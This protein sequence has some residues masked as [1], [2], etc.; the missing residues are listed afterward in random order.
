MK[1]HNSPA[2]AGE[3]PSRT[4]PESFEN[5]WCFVDWRDSSHIGGIN[6]ASNYIPLIVIYLTICMGP[7]RPLD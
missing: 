4:S 3:L 2:L 1:F 5:F 6:L 7:C